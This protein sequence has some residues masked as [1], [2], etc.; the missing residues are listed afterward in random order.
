MSDVKW[1]KIASDIFDDDKILLIESM[2]DADAIIVIW[3][4]LLCMA[5]KQNNSGVFMLNDKI[6]YTDEML[7]TIFR[8]PLNTVRL[9][10]NTFEQFGMIEIV[11]NA[12]T[13]PNWEKHQKLDALEKSRE[14]T[15]KRVARFRE[16]QK[17]LASG[18]DKIEAKNTC[19]VTETSCNGDR[20]DKIRIDK[21]I[22]NNDDDIKCA[23]AREGDTP[24]AA[25]NAYGDEIYEPTQTRIE[26]YATE[27]LRYM[28]ERAMQEIVSFLEDLPEPV[29]RHGIDNAL[30]N[31]KRTWSYVRAILNSYV[32]EGV[33]TVQE[34]VDVDKKHSQR[35]AQ[36]EK[37]KTVIPIGKK[38]AEEESADFWCRVKTY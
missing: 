17:I 33:K 34:A 11:N 35:Y 1:I 30:D 10:L 32:E 8:R 20:I 12:I 19:N 37:P 28:G 15:R 23:R 21:N 26:Q 5:G 2:P 18:T 9:A 36:K 27:N 16:K 3:F 13:I 14:T 6:A 4:K 24:E 31:D 25:P 38:T 29:I 7:S 22:Y